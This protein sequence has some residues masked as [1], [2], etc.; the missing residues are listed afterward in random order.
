M[1]DTMKLYYFY[2]IFYKYMDKYI[3]LLLIGYISKYNILMKYI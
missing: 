3:I 2:Y 1:G